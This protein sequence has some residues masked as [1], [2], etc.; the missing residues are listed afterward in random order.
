MK[1]DTAPGTYRYL[2]VEI[3]SSVYCLAGKIMVSTTGAIGLLN[4]DTHSLLEVHD[5]QV[6]H[7][8]L[9]AA[10]TDHF[11][12]VRLAKR[13]IDAVCLQ[14]REELGPQALVRGGFTNVIDYPVRIGMQAIEIEGVLETPGRLDFA[15]LLTEGVHEF[16]PVVNATLTGLLNPSLHIECGGMLINRRQVHVAAALQHRVKHDKPPGSSA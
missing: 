13:Q 4:D 5:A 12:I 16:I 6:S 3:L 10:A 2:P 9:S 11:E 8:H 1:A 7:W 15:A 14:R